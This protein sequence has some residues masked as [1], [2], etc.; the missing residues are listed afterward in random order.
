MNYKKWDIHLE[1][2]FNGKTYIYIGFLGTLYPLNPF[3]CI[4]K[5]IG[6][7]IK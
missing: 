7:R 6:R 3:T 1:Y 4:L 5:W 2:P